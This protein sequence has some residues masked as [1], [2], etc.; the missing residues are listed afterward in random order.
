MDAGGFKMNRTARQ[1]AV[2]GG[3]ASGMM[4]AICAARE[5]AEVC[6]YEKNDRV[7]KKILATGNGKCNY[8]NLH[9]DASCYR[10][11]DPERIRQV[12]EGF[13]PKACRDFFEAL[14]MLTLEKN[15]YLY[16]ASA[17]AATVLDLLRQE[18]TH[19]GVK[20]VTDCEVL[21]IHPQEGQGFTLACRKE[22]TAVTFRADRVILSA[23]SPAGGFAGS[24]KAKEDKTPAPGAYGLLQDLGLPLV[25]VVPSLVQL[26]CAET[27]LKAVA[28]VRF[29]GEVL[30]YAEDS[31]QAKEQGEIQMTDYGVS[32]IPVF[33]LSRHAAYALRQKKKVYVELDCLP[34]FT[35]EDYQSYCKSRKPL[36]PE[37]TMEEFL[38]GMCNKKL[39][40]LF[41]KLVGIRPGEPAA[42]VD[43]K[44]LDQV[45]GL[46]RRFPLTVTA[47]NPFAQAQ[48]CAGGLKLEAVDEGLQVKRYPGLYV[49][50]ELLDV[51]GRCGGY[52]L[53]WAFA[54][55]RLAGISAVRE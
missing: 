30:L 2:V 51:D 34:W 53:Q 35:N 5:G 37:Q 18:L 39:A 23:G 12:I 44:R 21:K 46:F 50:G 9:M 6:I 47:T 4:A 1:I 43:T 31:L 22:G 8:S 29:Q 33:Q 26:R 41:L 32:G 15:G 25:P 36:Y 16:P 14:G 42:Q 38:E 48:V 45:Y 49:T 10:G 19:Q 11:G 20:I 55:G 3:G 7:G 40:V 28:G 13:P 27:Y 24:K 52:N 54:S 17:Q